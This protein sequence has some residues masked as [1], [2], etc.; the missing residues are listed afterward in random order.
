MRRGLCLHLGMGQRYET[1]PTHDLREKTFDFECD[2]P[3]CSCHDYF[4][5][6]RETVYV[7]PILEKALYRLPKD[8]VSGDIF[9]YDGRKLIHTGF[10]SYVK[11]LLAENERLQ[12]QLN[13]AYGCESCSGRPSL[14]DP[15]VMRRALG[16][17]F[18]DDPKLKRYA[19]SPKNTESDLGIE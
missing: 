18:M 8:P 1:P 5:K 13:K 16:S 11:E 17:V 15:V 10:I 6:L 7:K 12:T 14:I 4:T 3:D 2:E 19:D 9:F